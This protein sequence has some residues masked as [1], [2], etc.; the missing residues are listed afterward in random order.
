MK[1][2]TDDG[3]EIQADTPKELVS[4]LHASSFAPEADDYKFMLHMAGR[5]WV[6][7]QVALNTESFDAFVQ[8]LIKTGIIKEVVS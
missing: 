5:V 7:R 6:S 3:H 2:I 4:K 1:F 8:D